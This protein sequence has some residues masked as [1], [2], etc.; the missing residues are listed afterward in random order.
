MILKLRPRDERG[1][2]DLDAL[3]AAA[4]RGPRG[5]QPPFLS[6]SA[7]DRL[8]YHTLIV[9]IKGK[10][11]RLPEKQKGRLLKGEDDN[12]CVVEEAR[13]LR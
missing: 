6:E 10:A 2:P 7:I 1:Q 12:G 8:L 9:H 4:P 13:N 3:M 5:Q 11:S